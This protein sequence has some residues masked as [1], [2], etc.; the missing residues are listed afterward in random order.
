MLSLAG[1]DEGGEARQ[2]HSALDN[3]VQTSKNMINKLANNSNL[4]RVQHV[5][6]PICHTHAFF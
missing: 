4:L 3:K 2:Q 5:L 1:L 6:T